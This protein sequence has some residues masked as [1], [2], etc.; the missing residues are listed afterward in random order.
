MKVVLLEIL[1]CFIVAG[2]LTIVMITP[3]WDCLSDTNVHGLLSHAQVFLY[4]L[5]MKHCA[6]ILHITH[7]SHITHLLHLLHL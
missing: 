7:I 6:H 1:D 5:H 4:M 2:E 3:H